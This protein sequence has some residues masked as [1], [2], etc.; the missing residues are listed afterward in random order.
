M[1]QGPVPSRT[2]PEES[3]APAPIAEPLFGDSKGGR[4]GNPLDLLHHARISLKNIA[5]SLANPVL[6]TNVG[7][8]CLWSGVSRLRPQFR[9]PDIS[10]DADELAVRF[11]QSVSRATG[12][13][14][15]VVVLLSGGL[16]SLATLVETAQ[17]CREDGRRLVPVVFNWVD[18]TGVAAAPVALRQAKAISGC[19]PPTVLHP[20]DGHGIDLDWSPTGPRREAHAEMWQRLYALVSNLP[21]PVVVTGEGGDEALAAWNFATRSLIE[22]RRVGQLRRYLGGFIR[23]GTVVD[24]VGEAVST[25]EEVLPRTLS[26]R[27]YM[28][29]SWPGVLAPA[30]GDVLMS[31]FRDEAVRAHQE[32]L[33]RRFV[34]FCEEGQSWAKANFFDQVYPYVYDAHS[35]A[36]PVAFR[37][38][39]CDEA[40]LAYCAGLAPAVRFD[41]RSRHPYHWYKALQL[42]LIPAE[43]RALAPAYKMLYAKEIDAEIRRDRPQGTWLLEELGLLR[44]TDED[45]LAR[46][47]PFLPL[48]ARNLELWL[49]GALSRGYDVIADA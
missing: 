1:Q 13:A 19:P 3:F 20:A 30:P 47:H 16:D 18:D 26:F 15:T 11:G 6:E 9:F 45:R 10:S 39:F 5:L 38:P 21:N 40:F 8:P 37:S 35:V 36:A 28:A 43:L 49:R 44:T 12:G 14:E 7:A 31:R 42:R 34:T 23:Y 32:W 48:V 2:T 4:A 46:A 29:C 17:Q 27:L 22:T 41:G 24:T 33:A 25:V